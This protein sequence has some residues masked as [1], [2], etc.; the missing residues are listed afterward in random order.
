MLSKEIEDPEEES[1]RRRLAFPSFMRRISEDVTL[2]ATDSAFLFPLFVVGCDSE[3]P[4]DRDETQAQLRDLASIGITQVTPGPSLLFAHA[5]RG[6]RRAK[7][8]S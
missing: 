4:R 1:L 7:S 3:S 6:S 2:V 8:A 5:N